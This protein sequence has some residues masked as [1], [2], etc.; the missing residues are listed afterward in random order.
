MGADWL[1]ANIEFAPNA[2]VILSHL[3]YA[4][5]NASSGMAI[6]T[7]SVAIE[8]ID[9]FANGFLAS[10]ARVVWALGWQ[11]GADVVNA[12]WNEDATMDAIFQTRYRDGVNPLN[13]WIGSNPGY[14]PSERVP[15]AEVH[16]DPHPSY[17]YLR[18]LTGD[19]SFTTNEWRNAE[20]VPDDTVAPVLGPLSAS[21]SPV[22]VATESD[23]ELPVFTPNGDGRSDTIA[24]KHT[25][26]ESAFLDIEVTSNGDHVRRMSIWAVR[27]PG[28]TSWDGRGDDGRYADDGAV[29]ITITPRD[30]AGNVGDAQ[31]V[32]VKVLASLDSPRISPPIFDPTDGDK[33]A[34]TAKFR[35][36]LSNPATVSWVIRDKAG[37]VVRRAVDD[38]AMD[39]GD[40]KFDWDGTDDAGDAVSQGK[41]TA[42]VRVTRPKGSYGHD[43]TLYLAP[44]KFTP[45]KWALKRGATVNFTIETAEAVKWKPFVTADREGLKKVSIKVRKITAKKFVGSYKTRTAGKRGPLKIAVSSTD[46]KGGKQSKTFTLRLR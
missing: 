38:V 37:T 41:Y 15:G 42:R 19:L 14:Y 8:R 17:G 11:P 40:I 31:S 45:S 44:F 6:P 30:R 2:V 16:I 28:K 9:N 12:L 7:R 27:G 3:S 13:G 5:G 35:A 29:R 32:R 46:I 18:G 22:T 43:L 21:Q 23:E 1:R 26:S 36:H 39:P 33:L 4:S 10:G 34:A 24:I 25:L 20:S